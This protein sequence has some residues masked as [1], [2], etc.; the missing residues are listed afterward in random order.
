M[1]LELQTKAPSALVV[2]VRN[3]EVCIL[4]RRAFVQNA[5]GPVST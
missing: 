5:P 4:F 3:T 1:Q 2:V